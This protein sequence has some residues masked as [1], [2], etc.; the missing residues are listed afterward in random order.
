MAR[1]S[2]RDSLLFHG[3]GFD[4]ERISETLRVTIKGMAIALIADW[5]PNVN[6]DI[7]DNWIEKTPFNN[8]ECHLSDVIETSIIYYYH[9]VR[10]FAVRETTLHIEN[11]LSW[12]AIWL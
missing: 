3:F 5:V 1:S 6:I 8:A 11:S 10:V 7:M 4:A 12:P 9:K 2:K